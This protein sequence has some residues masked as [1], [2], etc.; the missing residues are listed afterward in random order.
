MLVTSDIRH[1]VEEK[2]EEFRYAQSGHSAVL[3][4]VPLQLT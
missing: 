3:R 4:R 2:V 1:A